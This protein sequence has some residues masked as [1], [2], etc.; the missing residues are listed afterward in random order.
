VRQRQAF[1][2]H[3]RTDGRT[4]SSETVSLPA[5]ELPMQQILTKFDFVPI[6]VKWI[7]WETVWFL[8]SL[9]RPSITIFA[10]TVGRSSLFFLCV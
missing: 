8:C 5:Q 3:A 1:R 6:Y 2:T 7:L 4:D 10:I 9:P